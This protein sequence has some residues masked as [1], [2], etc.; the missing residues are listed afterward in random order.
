MAG[1]VAI[2]FDQVSKAQVPESPAKFDKILATTKKEADD[3]LHSADYK[4]TKESLI[5][6]GKQVVLNHP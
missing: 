3:I 5:R 6:V 4:L 1:W 2:N